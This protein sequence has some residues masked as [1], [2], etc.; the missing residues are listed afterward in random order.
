VNTDERRAKKIVAE[1]ATFLDNLGQLFQDFLNSDYRKGLGNQ[2]PYALAVAFA[3]WLD[4]EAKR[5][6]EQAFMGACPPQ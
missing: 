3:I 1:T 6:K 2:K 4:M 5:L